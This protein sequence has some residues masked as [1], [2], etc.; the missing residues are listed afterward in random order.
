MMAW[1]ISHVRFHL[2]GHQKQQEKEQPVMASGRPS[3]GRVGQGSWLSEPAG[4]HQQ[5]SQAQ[6]ACR[7]PNYPLNMFTRK[8]N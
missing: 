1:L 6:G 4:A 8:M 3:W 7:N 2:W 5:V